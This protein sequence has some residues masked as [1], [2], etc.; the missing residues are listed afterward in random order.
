MS[1]QDIQSFGYADDFEAFVSSQNEQKFVTAEMGK[2]IHENQMKPNIKKTHSLKIKSKLSAGLLDKSI[3]R[4]KKQRP[5][6]D[7]KFQP[8]L[9]FQLSSEISKSHECPLPN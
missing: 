7:T 2:W 4:C 1:L 3:E 8:N 6:F 5:L 9:E